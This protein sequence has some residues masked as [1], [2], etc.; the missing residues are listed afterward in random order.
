MSDS[1]SSFKW[2]QFLTLAE[3]LHES[4]ATD[5]LLAEAQ[6]RTVIGRAYYAAFNVAKEYLKSQNISIPKEKNEHFEV[7]NEFGK[8]FEKSNTNKN[9]RIVNKTLNKL[10]QR[11]NN[12]DYDSDAYYDKKRS[13]ALNWNKE[14]GYA[15]T[16]AKEVIEAIELLDKKEEQQDKSGLKEKPILKSKNPNKRQV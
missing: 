2:T 7:R 11:R 5:T 14:S 4:A 6:Y 9:F 16:R 8:L 12:A 15:I 10:R 3:K 13:K 1:S